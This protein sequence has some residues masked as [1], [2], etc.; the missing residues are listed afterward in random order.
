MFVVERNIQ[1]LPPWYH[2]FEQYIGYIIHVLL[3][4]LLCIPMS[5]VP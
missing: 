1:L 3:I 4:P 5:E 2:Q